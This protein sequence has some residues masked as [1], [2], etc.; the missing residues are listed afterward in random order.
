VIL[1]SSGKP[2]DSGYQVILG[3]H[4]AA[5]KDA[6]GGAEITLLKK[7]SLSDVRYLYS[8]SLHGEISCFRTV[9][10]IN[11]GVLIMVDHGAVPDPM[12]MYVAWRYEHV[13]RVVTPDLCLD[14]LELWSIYHLAA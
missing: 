12:K 5:A 7:T 14:W 1:T 11:C 4:A 6:R 8:I 13:N 9:K 10:K 2:Q 3:I